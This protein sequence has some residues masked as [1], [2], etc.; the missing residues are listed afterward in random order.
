MT[1]EAHEYRE[2]LAL[3]RMRPEERERYLA[4]WDEEEDAE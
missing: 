4:R 2:T 1:A 3:E